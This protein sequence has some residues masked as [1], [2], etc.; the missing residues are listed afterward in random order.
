[1]NRMARQHPGRS[2]LV[3]A[4]IVTG[5]VS[6]G[7]CSR[8]VASARADT[9]A[10]AP[11]LTASEI[12]ELD[13]RYFQER[14]G[15]DPTGASDLAR[16]GALYLER[17][18]ETGDPRDI[19]LADSVARKSLKN[20]ATNNSAAASV[21]QSALV[22]LHRFDQAIVLAKAARDAE[23]DNQALR[24]AVG[25]IEME[26]GNYDSAR[27]AFTGLR[28][29]RGD[30][31]IAPRLARWAE[32]QG[33]TARARR[34]LAGAL[35]AARNEPAMP[36]ERLAWYW[37]RAGDVEMRTGSPARADSLYRA[38]LAAHPGDYRLLSALAH[39]AALQERWTA[40]IEF[41]EEAI[42]R[43]LDPA[44]LGTLS[45][46]WL[47]AGDTAAAAE[48]ARVLE[49]VVSKQPGAYHR[50]WS[51]YLLDHDRHVNTVAKKIREEMRTRRDIY[52][53]DLLAWSLHKQGK[54]REASAAMDRA[55]SQGTKDPQL[56]RHAAAIA[57]ASSHQERA[58]R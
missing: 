37:L 12:R 47:A 24:A 1:M 51:L 23:P 21:L 46:A 49:V 53:Y 35:T 15:R 52:A 10:T 6:I 3:V 54:H 5:A 39:N 7:G 44:T 27:V 2:A 13:I 58:R 16:L 55:L 48:Y 34:L 50:A 22:G 20:R 30:L 36:A 42:T 8:G 38:G 31:H 56:L 25:E 43:T 33:D 14:A 57:N 40:A 19:V 28:I 11:A 45:D 9:T 32:I 17:A 26:L 29:G 4:L 41:G 18:R